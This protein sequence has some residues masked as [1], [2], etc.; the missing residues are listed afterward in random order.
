MARRRAVAMRV[1]AL[2]GLLGDEAKA[3]RPGQGFALERLME[4]L[5]VE[6]IRGPQA[7]NPPAQPGLLRGLADPRIG[8]ALRALHAEVGRRWS[9]AA[10][11]VE[12]GM[13]RSGFA[14]HFA[15][16]VGLPPIDYLLRWRMALAKDA[17]R[18]DGL[19]LAEV[20]ER[21]GYGSASAFSIAFTRSTGC[22][23]SV[24]RR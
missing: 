18:Q 9:V 4:L 20:A 16:T 11:A 6:I 19:S 24:F 2:L 10:L 17:L 15:E 12:A 21:V 13:S 5:L 3:E 7:P 23:P 14:A 8:R 1:G 22:A